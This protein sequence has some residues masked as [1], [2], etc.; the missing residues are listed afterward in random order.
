MIVDDPFSTSSET[1]AAR[2]LVRPG[3]PI[4]VAY[5]IGILLL[6][7]AAAV[8][9]QLASGA[10]RSEFGGYPDEPA[11]YV[12]SLM[13][14]DYVTQLKPVSPMK[15]A[16]DYY[17]HYPKV[18]FGHWPPLLY[19]VQA[20]WMLVFSTG[21]ASVLLELAL[22]TA[23]VAWSVFYLVNRHFGWKSGVVSG[24]LLTCLPI[25]QIYT[26]EVMAET[27]LIL[28]SLWAAIFFAR[29]LE[30]ERW[31][32]SLWFGIFS[33][34]AILTKGN[35]WEIGL[36][37]PVALLLTR[38]WRILRLPSFWLPVAIVLVLCLPWQL[39]TFEWA[40]Q[41]WGGGDKPGLEFAI[42]AI[43]AFV[44]IMISF[45]G[46]ILSAIAAVGIGVTVIIPFFRKAVQADW[47]VMAGLIFGVW[48]FH[49]IV[50]AGIE[51]RKMIVAVPALILFL[52]AGGEWLAARLPLGLRLAPWR[53][54][55][56]ALLLGAIFFSQTFA[57][58]REP[59]YGFTEAAEFIT[60][61]PQL[62]SATVLV[63]SEG[64]GEGLLVSEVAMH[65]PR[66]GHTILRASKVL[67][68]SNWIGSTYHALYQSAAALSDYLDR[69]KVDLVVIDSF[70][71]RAVH[72]DMTLI[73]EAIRQNPT[74]WALLKSFSADPPIA[75]RIEIYRFKPASHPL[76]Y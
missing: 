8:V 63:A 6:F 55:L 67:S 25:V 44:S 42:Q 14:H 21:R 17:A 72:Q 43:V 16:E 59:H 74:Q 64:D 75:G 12:T 53:P 68:Q 27:L 24:L 37:P 50:P 40:H 60:N 39:L 46:P 2:Q 57:I 38:K 45:M 28:V 58:P 76:H 56:L 11:H 62:R 13:V 1:Q 41:G 4:P 5:T 3:P 30:T 15:F 33:S 73:R 71:G 22:L 19:V 65:E 31:Q 52:F 35:G 10:Y 51:P 7:F 48:I 29:Y 32:D 26:D 18:A 36:A 47:A 9:L 49:V 20:A 23:L 61:S 66:P 69:A 54:A 70:H 34:L